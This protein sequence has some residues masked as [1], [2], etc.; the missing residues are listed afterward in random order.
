MKN[1]ILWIGLFLF[2][3][4]ASA[5]AEAGQP[6]PP[7]SADT[8]VPPFAKP[9]PPAVTPAERTGTLTPAG[10]LGGNSAAPEGCVSEG[11][12]FQNGQ[13]ILGT[14]RLSPQVYMVKNNSDYEQLLISHPTN[15]AMSEHWESRLDQGQWSALAMNQPNFVINCFGRKPGVAGYVDCKG[16]LSVCSYPKATMG[17]GSHW[18]S[19]NQSLTDT[20]SSLAH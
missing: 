19:E 5:N 9:L 7:P 11:F 8:P 18:A 17:G 10:T 16:V 6:I 3:L 2:F 4:Q 20:I 14:S 12:L 1:K 13:L 15:T